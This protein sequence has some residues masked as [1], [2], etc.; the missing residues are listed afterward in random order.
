MFCGNEIV[1]LVLGSLGGLILFLGILALV[2][3]SD[4][5][6][7]NGIEHLDILVGS[8]GALVC[9]SDCNDPHARANLR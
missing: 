5:R 7:G 6:I 9:I 3:F 1:V 4:L 2:V 8:V